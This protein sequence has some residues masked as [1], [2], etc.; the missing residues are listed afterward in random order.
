M[1]QTRSAFPGCSEELDQRLSWLQG[2]AVFAAAQG[3]ALRRVLDLI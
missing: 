2:C 1:D 3:P